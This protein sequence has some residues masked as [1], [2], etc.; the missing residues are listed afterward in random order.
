MSKREKK[1]LNVRPYRKCRKIVPAC[2]LTLPC[3]NSHPPNPKA[4]FSSCISRLIR[5]AH[6]TFFLKKCVIFEF[7]SL[8]FARNSMKFLQIFADVLE[9]VEIFRNC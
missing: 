3:Q 7:F 2:M 8:I 5:F 1:R 6:L 9:D 4:D